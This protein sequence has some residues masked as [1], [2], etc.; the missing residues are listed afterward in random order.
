MGAPLIAFFALS[1]AILYLLAG[2]PLLLLLRSR[3][4]IQKKFTPRT[5]TVL[6][7]V[8]NGERWLEQ[9]LTSLMQLDY[10]RE[11]LDIIVISDGST[12]ATE[13]IAR[14]WS[15]RGIM[16]VVQ[17]PE[18]KASALNAGIARARGEIL[19]FTDVR[20]PFA[21][22]TLRELVAC[23]HDPSVGVVSGELIIREGQSF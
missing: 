22:E 11:L 2:Y 1:A 5:V 8:K 19:L 16:L 7:A 10:P 20:Q 21:P 15:D 4:P 6:L 3:R 14:S 23:F 17:P 12:D 13:S 9:K 18:G